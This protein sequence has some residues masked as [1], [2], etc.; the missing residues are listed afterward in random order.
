[1]EIDSSPYFRYNE[2]VYVI[3]GTLALPLTFLILSLMISTEYALA[4]DFCVLIIYYP[5]S[6]K[7]ERFK[8][9]GI[10]E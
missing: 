2:Y 8:L 6:G 3:Y 4:L 5:I 10:I 7:K 9:H 1:M